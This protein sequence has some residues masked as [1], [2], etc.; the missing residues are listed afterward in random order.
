MD[1]Y[2]LF[3]CCGF[4]GLLGLSV[5]IVYWLIVFSVNLMVYVLL[6]LLVEFCIVATLLLICLGFALIIVCLCLRG[7]FV[8]IGVLF[9]L[10]FVW[11]YCITF[12]GCLVVCLE[13]VY[14]FC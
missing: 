13:L 9:A 10:C 5:L 8:F 3:D 12:V 6:L 2:L 14:C 4:L 1:C 7:L 11:V